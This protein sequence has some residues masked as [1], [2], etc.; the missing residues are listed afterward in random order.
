MRSLSFT[1]ALRAQVRRLFEGGTGGLAGG[2]GNQRTDETAYLTAGIPPHLVFIIDAK[3]QVPRLVLVIHTARA[4][5]RDSSQVSDSARVPVLR[6]VCL[7]CAVF[8]CFSERSGTA[9]SYCR[10][11]GACFAC[12]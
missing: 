8:A 2:L 4:P 10:L 1:R 9:G 12:R 11:L 5:V 6:G 3:S 7:S